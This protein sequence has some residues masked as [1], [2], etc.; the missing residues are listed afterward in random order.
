M[1]QQKLS[2]NFKSRIFPRE[3]GVERIICESEQVLQP[4]EAS[5]LGVGRR[6][7]GETRGVVIMGV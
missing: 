2:E 5:G 7:K 6:R 1:L 4:Y 3:L